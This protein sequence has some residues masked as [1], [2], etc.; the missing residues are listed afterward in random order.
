MDTH[1]NN[2]IKSVLNK[3]IH[4]LTGEWGL[5]CAVEWGAIKYSRKQQSKKWNWN[6]KQSQ[7]Y[8]AISWARETKAFRAFGSVSN[9]V[10]SGVA[11]CCSSLGISWCWGKFCWC[12]H[13]CQL[14]MDPPHPREVNLTHRICLENPEPCAKCSPQP[15][16][17]PC[18]VC[19]PN[20]KSTSIFGA[21]KTRFPLVLI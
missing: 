19:V 9:V 13:Q 21:V 10:R 8:P 3:T 7:K 4:L 12:C 16:N 15:P 11:V 14:A 5:K 20:G 6:K 1:S 2:G 17:F 18:W